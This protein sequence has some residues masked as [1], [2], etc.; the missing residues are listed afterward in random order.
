[1]FVGQHV[2]LILCRHSG[3]SNFEVAATFLDNF[4]TD[5]INI[6]APL[7]LSKCGD[8]RCAVESAYH[9][10]AVI[11][12]ERNCACAWRVRAKPRVYFHVKWMLI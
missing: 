6:T 12:C 9:G 11:E 7:L 1:M 10:D 5:S 2:E 8:A 3:T 4:R